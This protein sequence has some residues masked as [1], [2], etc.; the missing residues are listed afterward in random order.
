[1]VHLLETTKR[2]TEYFIYVV[3]HKFYP[4]PVCIY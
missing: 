4:P 2:F 1:M 3:K